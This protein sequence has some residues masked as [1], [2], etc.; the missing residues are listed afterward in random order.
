MLSMEPLPFRLVSPE[1]LTL[2][3]WIDEWRRMLSA[4]KDLF[5]RFVPF[6]WRRS[7]K[8]LDRKLRNARHLEKMDLA[9]I[10]RILR[11]KL[12][13]TTGDTILVHSSFGALR[14][15]FTPSELI[16]LLKDLIGP[17]GNIMMPF[18]PTGHSISWLKNE[19]VFDARSVASAMGVLTNTF[20]KDPEVTIS[21]HPIKALAV[22]GKDK[23][24]LTAEHHMSA[25]PYDKHSPYFKTLELP[26]SRSVGL[27]IDVIS[28]FHCCEDNQL[29]EVLDALYLPEPLPGK[30]ALADGKV[31]EIRTYCH[32]PEK[33][34]KAGPRCALLSKTGCPGLLTIRHEGIPFYSAIHAEV[35]RH[36][37]RMVESGAYTT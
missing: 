1:R 17:S 25:T 24:W 3:C 20:A 21:A 28:F 10:E 8:R 37:Q 12:E 5:R 23:R 35:F 11:Q 19:S 32:D 18:Y 27:G 15:G 33:I 30:V 29:P 31:I 2:D 36:H 6:A 26:G 4:A 9:T 22:W 34:R 14:A 16:V 13:V 7:L